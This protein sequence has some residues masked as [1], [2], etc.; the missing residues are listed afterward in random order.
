MSNPA[1]PPLDDEWYPPV[2]DAVDLVV[3][4]GAMVSMLVAEQYLR[5][6]AMRQEALADARG[7]GRQL[8]GVVDRGIRLELAA[9][10]A[11]T[12]HAAGTL[13]AE[14]DALVNRY[15]SVLDSLGGARMTQ[16]HALVLI[17]TLDTVEPDCRDQLLDPAI[18]LAESQPVGTFRRKLR[19]LVDT[20]QA[21]TLSERHQQA[22]QS[23]RTWIELAADGMAYHHWYGPAVQIRAAHDRITRQAKI[24]A[25]VPEQTRTLDQIR[26]D[27][28]GDLLVDGD[29]GTLPPE[30]RGIRAT[31]FVTVPALALLDG[32]TATH[33]V[34]SVEGVGPIP[35][36]VAR[37]LCGGAKSWMRVLTHP[38]KGI[39]LSLGRKKYRP[40]ADL[41]RAARWRAETCVGP[42]C[43]MRASRCDIDHNIAWHEG[44]ETAV[45]NV[46]PLC[47]GHHT[48]RHDTDWRIEQIPDS[49]GV[50]GWTSPSGRVYLVEPER[51]T[52]TFRPTAAAANGDPPPF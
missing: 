19:T 38:E 21:Q 18:Q 30:A 34:A 14:A 7:R 29:A 49:G 1:P 23:R 52:P 47:K 25:T 20:V 8:L 4:A 33:G 17:E 2:P 37:E 45:W 11:I 46:A 24:L 41:K 6:E 32:D 48:V 26:S 3:E 16:R 43:G 35:I 50:I 39:V 22:V 5:V 27:I 10:L 44:G 9:A 31:V 15:P 42:G 36:E 28:V 12:E 51:R 40:P 13:L